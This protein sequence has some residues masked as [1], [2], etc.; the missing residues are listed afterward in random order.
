L[1]SADAA[2]LATH[3]RGGPENA[4]DHLA[5]AASRRMPRPG[6]PAR[7]LHFGGTV[8]P[9]V[10][11]AVHE[12]GRRLVVRGD[13]G[14]ELEFVLSRSSARYVSAAGVHGPRLALQGE[15]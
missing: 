2:S 4:C 3:A 1:A 5:V 11:V 13:E 10:I 14:E 7:I 12:H 15:R 8:Q 6:A 9:A